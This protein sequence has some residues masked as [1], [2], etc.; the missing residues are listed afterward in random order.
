MKTDWQ[1]IV[2]RLCVLQRTG[3]H[4]T[5]ETLFLTYSYMPTDPHRQ[6][7]IARVD[8]TFSSGTA[9]GW[10]TQSFMHST[11]AVVR[12]V[13][14]WDDR[15]RAQNNWRPAS[16]ED[17]LLFLRGWRNR[18]VD[19]ARSSLVHGL[20]A[21]L[22]DL[23][24]EDA[25]RIDPDEDRRFRRLVQDAGRGVTIV[26]MGCGAPRDPRND[27]DLNRFMRATF[28]SLELIW[29]EHGIHQIILCG[30]KTNRPDMSE[31]EAMRIWIE[32]HRPGWASEV[33]IIDTTTDIEGNF[34]AARTRI[35]ARDNVI[36]FCETSRKPTNRF[37]A[38]LAER[39]YVDGGEWL[40]IGKM[41]DEAS[42]S[43]MHRL[44]QVAVHLP[45][46]ALS[47][48]VPAVASIKRWMRARNIEKARRET[49]HI[50]IV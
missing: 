37:Y 20:N 49:L 4:P 5:D 29:N 36:V 38:L 50:E 31:A 6:V 17:L 34:K 16:D 11:L 19:P 1:P 24:P 15:P 35:P 26:I 12:M 2:G 28:A 21:N 32:A 14:L 27:E 9:S 7:I 43:L 10:R 44:K 22:E 48:A 45:V 41:R 8:Q 39:R 46:E 33:V 18:G 47:Q 3:T 23:L 40:V 30:G 13:D 25:T 42:L